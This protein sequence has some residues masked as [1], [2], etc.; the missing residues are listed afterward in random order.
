M[1]GE[2]FPGEAAQQC[3]SRQRCGTLWR[4]IVDAAIL[5]MV[6]I[7]MMNSATAQEVTLSREAIIRGNPPD[8]VLQ[9]KAIVRSDDGGFII[10]GQINA[11][12]Q[13]WAAK[14]DGNGNVLWRYEANV[15]DELPIGDGAEFNGA[16]VMPDGSTYL[17]GSM[18]RPR[19]ERPPALLTHLDK[20][21][22]LVFERLVFP[23]KM[24][25][26][27]NVSF[28]DCI[29]WGDGLVLLGRVRQYPEPGK[30][31]SFYW[32]LALDAQGGMKWES[33]IPTTF[34][35][36]DEAGSLLATE[37]SLM[38][39]GNRFPKTELFRVSR[40]GELETR[41][42]VGGQFRFVHPTSNDGIV[43]IFGH[44]SKGTAA[45]IT[46]NDRFEEVRNIEGTHPENFISFLAYRL[47]NQSLVL[48]G[49]E[50][51]AGG[52]QFAS[53]VVSVDAELRTEHVLNLSGGPYYDSGFVKAAVPTGMAGEFVA[54][55]DLLKKAEGR[56]ARQ[57]AAIDFIQ[58]K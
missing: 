57:G 43:Q 49:S 21:G 25:K 39:S 16:V 26:H 13:A 58:V 14:T 24:A 11:R 29:R 31:E 15:K 2:I 20:E 17:C 36:I 27:G 44:T 33:L 56:D 55:R 8:V 6:V 32:L 40:A 50:I 18:P 42:I 3:Q 12:Q 54:A 22:R 30:D 23:Q 1:S 19:G 45:L 38:F 51:K 52:A 7:V 48:F 53:R 34:D 28:L 5:S 46:I 9:P 35:T 37:D 41:K 47:P 4:K 10:A